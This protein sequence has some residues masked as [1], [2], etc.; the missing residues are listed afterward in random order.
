MK[1]LSKRFMTVYILI[2]F[3]S[4]G[5]FASVTQPMLLDANV[6]SAKWISDE[7]GIFTWGQAKI[8]K[9]QPYENLSKADLQAAYQHLCR[10]TDAVLD[11]VSQVDIE[12]DNNFAQCGMKPLKA[13]LE[14]I[15]CRGG[16]VTA[17]QMRSGFKTF[18][19]SLQN[20][21]QAQFRKSCD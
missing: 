12:Q 15:D 19:N 5:A 17:A 6:A 9:G 13:K 16:D 20:L 21:S 8:K 18:V 3:F 11:K 10:F 1:C 14:S 4:M 7:G 2:T